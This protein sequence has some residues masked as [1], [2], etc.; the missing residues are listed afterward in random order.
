MTDAEKVSAWMEA[1]QHPMKAEIDAVRKIIKEADLRIAE[2]IKWAAP[3]YYYKQDLLTFNHRLQQRV[4]LV[5]HHIAITGI[6]SP[7]LEGDYKDRRMTYFDSMT[8]IRAAA[9]ELQRIIGLLA[10]A[11]KNNPG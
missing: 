5:F 7:L 3:S 2:R 1:L 4:H 8:H 9:P 11:M 10:D 6:A